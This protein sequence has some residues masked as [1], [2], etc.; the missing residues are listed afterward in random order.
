MKTIITEEMRYRERVVQYAI[1]SNNAVAARRYHTSRQ[2]VQ[3]WRK[4]YDGT[5]ASLS[6]K[7]TRPHSHPNQH[8]RE[9]IELIKRMHRRYSFEGLAQVYRSLIDAGYTRTYQSM[10]KQLR[11]L[12]LKQPEKKKYPKSKYKAIKGEYPG[13]YVEVDVKYVPLE[14]IGFSSS[15]ARY[16]QI[17]GIDLYS[18]KRI[19]KLVNELSTYETSKFLYSLEKSMGFKIKTIQTD[20][21]REFCNDTD[22][23]QSLFQIVLERLGI[24]HK[25]TRPYSPWQNGVVERSHRVDNEIFYVRRRFSSEEEMY[26]SFKRYAART[27]NICRGILKF[28]SPNE[29]LREYLTRVA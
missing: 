5:T 21:G 18:R 19:I 9:E 3:R 22:K 20:N 29:V 26:K 11:N 24:R 1:K 8:T 6:N 12:R 23:A 15:H 4:K 28:K 27:N 13:E 2:Q 10:Q 17:T 14:C 25:R 7:S 16:Y